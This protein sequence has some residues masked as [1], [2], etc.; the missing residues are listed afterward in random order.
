MNLSHEHLLT[1][2]AIQ[3]NGYDFMI[4]LIEYFVYI[5]EYV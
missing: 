1:I 3:W 2:D 4:H 5:N